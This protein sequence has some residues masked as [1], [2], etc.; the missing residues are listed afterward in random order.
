VLR[1]S[2]AA[3]RKSSCF[4]DAVSIIFRKGYPKIKGKKAAG[5]DKE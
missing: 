1:K 5:D 2:A 3:D 4:W